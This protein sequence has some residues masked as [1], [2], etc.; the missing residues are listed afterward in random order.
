M[1]EQ[2]FS[3]R[4]IQS[5]PH[6][7][8]RLAG[9][10]YG[11][12]VVTGTF[13]LGIAPERLFVGDTSQA[14]AASIAAQDW[15]LRVSI[16]AEAACYLAFACLALALHALLRPVHKG[17]AAG[18]AMLVLISVPFGF[19]NLTALMEMQR[20]VESGAALTSTEAIA[21]AH[22][23]YRAGHFLQSAPWGLW[24]L[25]FGYLALRS[26]FM[27]RLLGLGLILAGA[28]YVAHFAAR[29]LVDGYRE[30]IWPDVFSAP[31]IAEVLTAFW[32]LVFGARRSLWPSRSVA[33]SKQN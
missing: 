33:R 13:S 19:A 6:G 8:A 23:R 3:T 1:N 18:M 4:D 27:P 25:P 21:D 16:L 20:I 28:G 2:L 5:G 7:Q 29:L 31:R 14:L 26:A 9:A 24:L 22:A 15:L 11:L 30:S 32:L 17:A 10:F 12:V